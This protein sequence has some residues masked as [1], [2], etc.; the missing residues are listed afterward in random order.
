MSLKIDLKKWHEK[1][2]KDQEMFNYHSAMEHT[3]ITAIGS[4][5]TQN[6]L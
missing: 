3:L 6:S 1:T 4:S 5:F 2:S